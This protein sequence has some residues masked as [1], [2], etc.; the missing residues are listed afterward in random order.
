MDAKPS[1]IAQAPAPQPRYLQPTGLYDSLPNGYTHVVTV[2]EPLRWLFV[3]GQGGENA[4]AE[5]PD[6]F[7]L[8]AAQALANIK[9]ALAAGGADMGHVLK[10]TVLIVDH[11]LE[12]FEHWQSAVRQHWGSGEPGDSGRAPA[13]TLIP[14]PKLALPGMLIEV[15]ATAALPMAMGAKAAIPA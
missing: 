12:R 13:C 15:E 9:T 4:L 11:S 3:S 7:A 10:L 6:S 1:F 14:V 2:Q 5:L 8:Q